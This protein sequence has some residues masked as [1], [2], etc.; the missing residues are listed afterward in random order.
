MDVVKDICDK[1]AIMENGKIIE[2]N[3][4]IE[5]FRNPKTKTTKAFINSLSIISEE[6][7][8]NPKEFQGTII[9]LSFFR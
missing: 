7:Y 8:I 9:R 2:V 4:P 5:L 1:V 6:E 3:T